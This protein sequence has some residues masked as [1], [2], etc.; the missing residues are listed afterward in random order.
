[1]IK[2][3]HGVMMTNFFFIINLSMNLFKSFFKIWNADLASIFSREDRVA[4]KSIALTLLISL[5]I[6]IFMNYKKFS[7]DGVK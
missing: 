7:L 6:L 1:M 5:I 4:I 3:V 2:G